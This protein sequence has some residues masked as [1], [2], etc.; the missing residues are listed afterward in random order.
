MNTSHSRLVKRHSGV[1][2]LIVFILAVCCSGFSALAQEV[3]ATITGI[4]TDPTGRIVANADIKAQDLDRGTIWPTRTNGS[5][6]YTITRLPV[7]RYEVRVISPGFRT[8]MESPIELQLNQVASGNIKLVLGA[9]NE[10]VQ[11]TSEAPLL[12]T[13]TTDVGTV[14]DARTNVSLPLA[15]R[16]YLQLTL[17]TPGAVTVQPTGFQSGQNAGQVARPEINGN[18]FDAN[19]YLLDGMDNNDAGSNYVAYSPQPDAIQEF[20]VLT[21]NAPA[22][23]GNY[24]GGVISASIKEGTNSFHGSAFEFFRNDVLN[25]NQWMNKLIPGSIIPRQKL[26][27]NEFGGTIGGPILKDKLFFFADYQGERFDFP[28]TTSTITVFTAKERTGDVSELVAAGKTIVDP[29]TGLPFA[30][31]VIPQPRLSQTALAIVNSQYYPTPING[32]LQANAHNTTAVKTDSDQGD[33][34]ID[35]AASV[36]DHFMGR[37]SYSDLTN[38]TVNSFAL[39]YNPYNLVSTWNFVTGYT[40]TISPNLLN[41]ARLGVNYVRVGQNQTT[42]NFSGDATSLFKIPGL[43]TSFLPAMSFSGGYVSN[44]GTKESVTDNYDT[45]VQYSDVVNWVRGKHSMR[46]GFQGW[47]IRTNGLFNGSNGQAGSFGFNTTYSGSPETDFLLGLPTNVGVGNLGAE[48]GQ[49]NNVFAGFVQDDWKVTDRLTFNLGFRYE[50]H[51]PFVEA[52]DKEV[53]WDPQT[54]TFELPGQ[55]GNSRALYNS[56]NGYGNYQPRVGVAYQLMP[57]TTVRASYG[58]SSFMEGTGLGLRLPGNPPQPIAASANYSALGYPTTTLDQGFTPIAVPAGCTIAGLESA[59]PNCYKGA[60]IYSWDKHVQPAHSNQWSLFVQHELSPSAIVQVG[61]VGQSTTHL[62]NAELL[63]QLVWDSPGVVSPSPFFAQNRPVINQLA[64]IFGTFA[65]AHQNY[66]A[67]QTQM[68]G[69]LNHGLSYLLSYTWSRCMTNSQG[70]WG[71]GGQSQAPSAWWQNTY[72]PSG[73]NGACYYNVKGVFT[74][75]VIYDLPFGR[76]R[77]FGTNMNR[78]ADAVVGG[79]KVNVIPTFRGGFPLTLSSNSDHSGTNSFQ[80]RPDCI[81]SPHVL[82]KQTIG[83]GFYGYRWF[84]PASY[85]EPKD[86]YFGNCSVSSVY[87]PGEQNIDASIAK[88]FSITDHQN[89]EFRTEFINA[90]N[91]VILDAPNNGGIDIANPDGGTIGQIK[92]SEGA[93]NIQFALKYNF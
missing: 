92:T 50:T 46:F 63:T 19:S 93:R 44:F 80:N 75:Y 47:R 24:M 21:Q 35:Y 83:N 11:V 5:G 56:Y 76:G 30:D 65:A 91:H 81:A 64:Y 6:F 29:Q 17:L 69:R 23:F 48:W 31:N 22:D 60:I 13:D 87:G 3:T 28:R 53:N 40:R 14:I 27:W 88:T 41:D 37:F 10:T 33:G 74:G 38:P 15:S 55:N 66:N 82:H 85:Q 89:I 78:A 8:A 79:W 43:T 73:E 25:A 54:G 68:Q 52:N 7:G 4:V 77:Q 72:N 58:L 26:R 42:S 20:R 32:L 1:R 61:Y 18:R 45:S 70:F 12:Q 62:T 67:L 9:A 51:T 2:A 36:K 49:R 71:E 34:R 90:F 39:D 59:A 57:K 86:G 84:D 16:N